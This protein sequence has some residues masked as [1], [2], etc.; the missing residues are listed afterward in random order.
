VT[1][2]CGRVGV[3]ASVILSLWVYACVSV[4]RAEMRTGVIKVLECVCVGQHMNAE[5]NT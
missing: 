1:A 2:V 3:G 5:V 4:T